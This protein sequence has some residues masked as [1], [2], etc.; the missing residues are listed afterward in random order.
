M[1]RSPVEIRMHCVKLLGQRLTARNFR[2]SVREFHVS[3][4]VLDGFTAL[5]SPVT[6]VVG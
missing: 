4:A 2:L 6:E 1:R 3:V 5:G